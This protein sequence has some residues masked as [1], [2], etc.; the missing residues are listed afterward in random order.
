MGL[1]PPS[2]L[3]LQYVVSVQIG[4]RWAAETDSRVWISVW[5]GQWGHWEEMFRE[6]C[7]R[8]QGEVPKESG[9]KMSH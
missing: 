2:F 7:E 8:K 1:H 6:K 9:G 5:G 3:V 4:N